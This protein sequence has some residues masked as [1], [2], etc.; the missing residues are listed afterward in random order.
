[1]S[2]KICEIKD[3]KEIRRKTDNPKFKCKKCATLANKEKHLCKA[4]NM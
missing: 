2:K 1:M 3:E 4:Q